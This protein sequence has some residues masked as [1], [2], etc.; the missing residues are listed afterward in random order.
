M[1]VRLRESEVLSL[2][3]GK[4]KGDI[5]ECLIERIFVEVDGWLY[6]WMPECLSE[7]LNVWMPVWIGLIMKDK[8]G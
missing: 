1:C 8:I 4:G 5:V 6:V 2:K 3:K 7:C